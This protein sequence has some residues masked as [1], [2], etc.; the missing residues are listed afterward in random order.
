[1]KQQLQRLLSLQSYKCFFCGHRIPDGEASVEHLH[2]ISKG[3]ERSDE[4]AVVCCKAVN[5]WLGNRS[6]KKKFAAILSHRGESM[7]LASIVSGPKARPQKTFV[8]EAQKL[9]P[10]VVKNLRA[11]GVKRPKK[12]TTLRNSIANSFQ[13]ASPMLIKAVTE[14]LKKNG[15]TAEKDGKVS[16][17]GLLPNKGVTK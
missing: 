7:C 17:P 6:V 3:G 13:Q 15:Y 10:K 1:M 11:L 4:N 2:A 16:Y 5:N 12:L 9:L 8:T 14:L